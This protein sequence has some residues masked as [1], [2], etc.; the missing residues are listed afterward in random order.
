MYRTGDLARFSS[1]HALHY[2]GRFDKQVKVRGVRL[3]LAEIEATLVQFEDISAAAVT[4]RKVEDEVEI[5]AYVVWRP[6][7]P[8]AIDTLREFLRSKVPSAAIPGRWVQV[9]SLPLLANGKVDYAALQNVE[10]ERPLTRQFQPPR[11]PLE[12]AVAAIWLEVLHLQSVGI[13]DNFFELGGHSLRA[14]Q[15]ISRVRDRFGVEMPFATIFESST[16]ADFTGVLEALLEQQPSDPATPVIEGAEYRE[17][18]QQISA[19][20]EED[21]GALLT[22]LRSNVS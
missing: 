11:T 1:D 3:E 9:E 15:V 16:I 13:N 21:V 2:L 14:S 4:A 7:T 12:Q 6:P 20:T 18:V 17:L 22:A 5:V 10:V 8:L 19:I